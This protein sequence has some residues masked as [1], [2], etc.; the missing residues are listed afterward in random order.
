MTVI[1]YQEMGEDFYEIYND[2]PGGSSG[3]IERIGENNIKFEHAGTEESFLY[4]KFITEEGNIGEITAPIPINGY[5]GINISEP[6]SV[7]GI[8]KKSIAD[9][10]NFDF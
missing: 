6:V 9:E 10:E 8:F 4:I 2:N 1:K 5:F 3:I 7:E